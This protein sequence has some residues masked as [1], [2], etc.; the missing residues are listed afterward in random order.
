MPR[1]GVEPSSLATHDFESCAYTNSA[2]E[3]LL[4]KQKECSKFSATIKAP[5]QKLYIPKKTPCTARPV[6][7]C[8]SDWICYSPHVETTQI[9][10]KIIVIVGQTGSGKTSLSITL[11][12]QFNGEVINADSRQVY[13]GLDIGT[14]KISSDEMQGVPHHLLSFVDPNETYDAMQFS[15]DAARSIEDITQRSKLPIIAGGTF[16]YIDMLLKKVSSAPVP[17]NPELRKEL[18]AYDES[19]LYSLLQE[20]D[21]A[22]AERIDKHN[23]RRLMR[24]LEILHTLPAIPIPHVSENPFDTLLIGISV[25]K[26][27]LKE[28]LQ[29]RGEKAIDRGLIEETQG[30]LA[31]GVTRER[32]SEIGLEYRI[33]LAYLDGT[34]T[35]QEL[36]Q[37]LK[38]KNWQYAKRQNLWLKRDPQIQWFA[39]ED[40]DAIT[41]QV[42]QFLAD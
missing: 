13:R 35:K 6:P 3:A 33:V 29:E 11:A 34:L 19:E 41:E 12:K 24:A 2:T 7:R 27:V 30:L 28:R 14:E 10:P 9:K 37:K 18:E 22:F 5:K 1:E 31:Q 21:A 17:P 8:T 25:D 26:E 16:F 40:M 32:L 38:E 4:C 39:R 20:K 36:T 23:K 42:Q 15:T